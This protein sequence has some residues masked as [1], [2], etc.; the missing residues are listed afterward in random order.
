M[1]GDLL[2]IKK[3]LIPTLLKSP[4]I[5][6]VGNAPSLLYSYPALKKKIEEESSFLLLAD[7]IAYPILKEYPQAPHIIFHV[8]PKAKTFLLP[9]KDA[10]IFYYKKL[11]L[12]YR[13]QKENYLFPFSLYKEEKNASFSLLS[14]GTVVGVAFSFLCYLIKEGFSKKVYLFGIDF[15]FPDFLY[16]GIKCASS[17]IHISRIFSREQ[18]EMLQVFQ[19]TTSLWIKSPYIIRTKEEFLRAKKNIEKML[20]PYIHKISLFDYSP[21]GLSSSLGKKQIPWEEG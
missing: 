8:D 16:G 4:S 3:K 21:L 6:I 13:V 17:Y 10:Y 14:P 18:E 11:P 5:S 12:P 1:E 9:L 7:S 2:L 20:L 15:S 19:Q